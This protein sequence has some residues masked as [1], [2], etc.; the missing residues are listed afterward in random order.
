MINL[1]ELD[2]CFAAQDSKFYVVFL[3]VNNYDGDV[4]VSTGL[5]G[6]SGQITVKRGETVVISEQPNNDNPISVTAVDT[7]TSG[8][9]NINGQN[10]ISIKPDKTFGASFQVLFL[11]VQKP[12]KLVVALV[13]Y[14][15]EHIEE[16][17]VCRQNGLALKFLKHT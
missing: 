4:I 15:S 9:V 6:P 17:N 11:G 3:L 2:V 7:A 1:I 13:Y 16:F 12:G 5:P 10:S 8:E 14:I